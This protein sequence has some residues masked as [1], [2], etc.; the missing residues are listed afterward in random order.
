MKK[1][2]FKNFSTAKNVLKIVI[3]YKILIVSLLFTLQRLSELSFLL[4]EI[5][6][7][8]GIDLRNVNQILKIVLQKLTNLFSPI[9][10]YGE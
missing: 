6:F 3:L 8:D 4:L 1:S 7:S 2:S 10:C 9:K 5:L